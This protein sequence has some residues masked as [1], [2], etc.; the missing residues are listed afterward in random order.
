[1]DKFGIRQE[2]TKN[3]TVDEFD[4]IIVP[5]RAFTKGRS[6]CQ[7]IPISLSFRWASLWSWWRL[8]RSRKSTLIDMT[9]VPIPFFQFLTAQ[10]CPKIALAFEEQVFDVIPTDEHDVKVDEVIYF[11]VRDESL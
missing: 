3:R 4:L 9:S 7:N 5:G 2:C 6:T 10:T 1:M 8:L 11:S